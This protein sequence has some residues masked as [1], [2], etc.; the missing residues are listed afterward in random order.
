MHVKHV[1]KF[2]GSQT[3]PKR[4]GHLDRSAVKCI[5]HGLASSLLGFSVYSIMGVKFDLILV[6]RSRSFEYFAR[7]FAPTCLGAP[8]SGS[9]RKKRVIVFSSYGKCLT[10][11]DL[12]EGLDWSGHGFG[13][14]ASPRPSKK[15]SK[16]KNWLCHPLPLFMADSMIPNT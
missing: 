1:C 16:K 6:L 11:I 7:S 9:S 12:F 15:N 2:S 5:N 13:A 8:G 10:V 3:S 4:R 14:S